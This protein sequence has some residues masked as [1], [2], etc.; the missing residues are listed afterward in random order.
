MLQGSRR[1]LAAGPLI[2]AYVDSAR[3]GSSL[4]TNPG[5]VH[6]DSSC[7]RGRRS[8]CTPGQWRYR[9]EG[10]TADDTRPADKRLVA[11]NGLREAAQARRSPHAGGRRPPS[12]AGR[13]CSRSRSQ[14]PRTA[15]GRIIWSLSWAGRLPTASVGR[16]RWRQIV[17]CLSTDVRPAA[18]H[19]QPP[20]AAIEVGGPACDSLAVLGAVSGNAP[21]TSLTVGVHPLPFRARFRPFAA[22]HRKRS[23]ARSI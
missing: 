11:G 3:K 12:P 6:A 13:R 15:S 19:F 17:H 21:V 9:G 5:T 14:R 7:P 1:P 23:I 22:P 18:T 2:C 4:T 20:P 8:S 16:P 10:G